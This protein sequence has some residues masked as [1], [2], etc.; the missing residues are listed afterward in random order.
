MKRTIVEEFD[1]VGRLK[2]RTTT[3]EDAVGQWWLLQYPLQPSFLP[4]PSAPP[5]TTTCDPRLNNC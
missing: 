2:R 1:E 5:F 3:E 4:D